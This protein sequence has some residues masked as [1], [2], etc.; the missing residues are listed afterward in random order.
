MPVLQADN[1]IAILRTACGN[2]QTPLHSPDW[3]TLARMAQIHSL[4]ALFYTGAVQY[5]E[6]E[7]CPAALRAKWQA[8]TIAV[9]ARQ[10]Q[11]TELFLQL[12]AALTAA[13]LRPLVLKG[14]VCRQLYGGLADYR[15]S[16]DEDLYIPP[17]Q[18]A[19]CREVLAR[20]GWQLTSHEASLQE[21]Y[22][23]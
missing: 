23:G 4:N 18:V 3:E 19:R 1:F 13:G 10:A 15:P 7:A 5:R 14:I 17:G 11:R 12:Y 16:C 8:D 9:V 6:F 20:N 22:S 21:M 2:G